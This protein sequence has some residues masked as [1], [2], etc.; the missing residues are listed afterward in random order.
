MI[1]RPPRALGRI[2][3][4]RR[5]SRTQAIV[6]PTRLGSNEP[7]RIPL[8]F[9][10]RSSGTVSSMT[11]P[12]RDQRAHLSINTR[13]GTQRTCSSQHPVRSRLGSDTIR[14]GPE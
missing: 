4:L 2:T 5:A 8:V 12:E 7:F 10:V 11:L 9:R 3:P 14:T 1:G 6:A 13:E